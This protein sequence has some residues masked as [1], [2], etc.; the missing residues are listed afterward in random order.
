MSRCRPNWPRVSC[1]SSTKPSSTK[2][3]FARPQEG[4]VFWG[5]QVNKQVL[6]AVVLTGMAASTAVMADADI[7]HVYGRADMSVQSTSTGADSAVITTE[8]N[9][10]RLGF[11]NT[12]QL[13]ETLEVFYRLEYEITFDERLRSSNKGFMRGRNSFVGL[14]NELGE[15]FLGMA[16]TPFKTSDKNIDLFSD[17]FLSDIEF[18]MVGQDR[19]SDMIQVGVTLPGSIKARVAMFPGEGADAED[20]KDP[21][22]GEDAD[23]IADAMSLSLGG[24]TVGVNWTVAYNNDV[25]DREVIRLATHGKLGAVKLGGLVQYGGAVDAPADEGVAYTLSGAYKFDAKNV[26]KLQY[27]FAENDMLTDVAR[28]TDGDGVNDV[29]DAQLWSIGYDRILAKSTKL[30]AFYT[31]RVVGDAED[32]EYATFGLGV[33]HDFGKKK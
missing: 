24:K 11:H 13:S 1:A 18:L 33:R 4:R 9:K 12:H 22:S 5:K 10:S 23:G 31:E 8:S 3:F 2:Q 17:V 14:R 26:I 7:P 21:V 20:S 6:S 19:V 15:V 16:D 30:Y 29:Q 28:D 32:E 25:L 27:S